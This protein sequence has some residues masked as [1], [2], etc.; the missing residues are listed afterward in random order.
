[1]DIEHVIRAWKDDEDQW[2]DTLPA[3]PVGVELTEEEL[4]LVSGNDCSVTI[5]C[6]STCSFTCDFTIPPPCKFSCGLTC[7]A[8]A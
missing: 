1:M 4:W 2:N 3:S 5:V 7:V 6:E 8:T